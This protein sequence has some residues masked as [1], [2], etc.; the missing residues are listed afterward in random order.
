MAAQQAPAEGAPRVD[1]VRRVADR[2]IACVCR[3]ATE[4]GRPVC[5]CCL[6]YGDR[7]LPADGCDCTC[8]MPD[9]SEGVGRAWARVVRY[10]LVVSG[11]AAARRRNACSLVP[12]WRITWE[13]GIWRCIRSV[14]DGILTC[15]DRNADAISKMYDDAILRRVLVCCPVLASQQIELATGQPIGPM[16]GCVASVLQFAA[17]FTP[18]PPEP[19]QSQAAPG[20]KMRTTDEGIPYWEEIV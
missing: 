2:L 9:G 4:A 16:G 19:G 11:T 15:P 18:L 3:Y 20:W 13:V 5:D 10:D 8:T 6:H 7:T 1:E 14:G 12:Q 17:N